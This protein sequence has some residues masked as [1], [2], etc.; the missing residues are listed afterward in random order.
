MIKNICLFCLLI[1]ICLFYSLCIAYDVSLEELK[2]A[3][4][5]NKHLVQQL[6]EC[7]FHFNICKKIYRKPW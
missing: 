3:K 6:N 5:Y 1:F 4:K 7:Q 2:E